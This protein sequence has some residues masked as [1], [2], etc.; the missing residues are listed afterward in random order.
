MNVVPSDDLINVNNTEEIIRKQ[1]LKKK[2]QLHQEQER[3]L[4]FK[5]AKGFKTIENITNTYTVGKELGAGAFGAVRVGQHKSTKVVVAIK[6]IKKALLQ[7]SEIYKELMRN[8]LQILEAADHPNITRVFELLED[9]KC[10]YIVM[11]F[12]SGGNLL[13]V[14]VKQKKMTERI[15][16]NVIY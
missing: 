6:V 5:A 13:D 1:S 10:F 11:E 15:A 2:S 3:I 4:G 7:E 12:C 9:K 14:I 8:E 16:C